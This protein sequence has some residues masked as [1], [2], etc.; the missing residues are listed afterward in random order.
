MTLHTW[1]LFVAAVFLL[2]GTPGPN[3]LHIM[4][5]SVELGLKRSVAAMAGCL[6]AIVIILTASAAGLT[7]LLLAVPGAFE[8]LRYAGVFYLVY[9]GLKALRTKA[10]PLDVGDADL[11]PRIS[12][13]SVFRGGFT[14]GVSN[15]KLI[16]FAAAFLPQFIDATRPQTVQFAILVVTFAAVETFWYGVYA[17]TGRS[18]SRYMGR[19]AIRRAFDR[20]TGVIFIGFGLALLRARPA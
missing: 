7:T 5:R 3:M 18:L 6:V 8:V 9:L 12:T 17:L 19:L 4:S 15:P 10:A 2:S 16:L 20:V 14:I 1:L 13:A 11:L